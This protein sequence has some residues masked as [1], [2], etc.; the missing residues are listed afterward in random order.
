MSWNNRCLFIQPIYIY[1]CDVSGTVVGAGETVAYVTDKGSFSLKLHFCSRRLVSK[2]EYIVCLWC[3]YFRE[4]IKQGDG[5]VF[6][7]VFSH[8]SE[9]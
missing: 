3:G 4:K 2:N 6:N 8:R 5:A 1:F 7:R 9:I